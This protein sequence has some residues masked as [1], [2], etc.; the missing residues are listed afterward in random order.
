MA[1]SAV[2]RPVEVHA[3]ADRIVIRQDGRIRPEIS[4][5]CD[6]VLFQPSFAIC[7]CTTSALLGPRSRNSSG[8]VSPRINDRM[9][10]RAAAM[11]SGVS[12][13]ATRTACWQKRSQNSLTSLIRPSNFV[14]P[15]ILVH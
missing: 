15:V 1:A 7:A 14:Q 3:Y 5:C 6:D 12:V 2:G 8:L 13:S 9:M 11:T 4:D 10:I